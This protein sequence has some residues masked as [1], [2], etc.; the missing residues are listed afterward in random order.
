VEAPVLDDVVHLVRLGLRFDDGLLK[1]GRKDPE[2]V[3]LKNEF[4][5]CA[6]PDLSWVVRLL[7]HFC[8]P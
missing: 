3:S 7:K 8:A 4:G 2:A 6:Q 5:L 1:R